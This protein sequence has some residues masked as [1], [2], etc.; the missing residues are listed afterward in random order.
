MNVDYTILEK[1][2]KKFAIVSLKTN[3]FDLLSKNMI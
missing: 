1:Y 3:I 2:Q